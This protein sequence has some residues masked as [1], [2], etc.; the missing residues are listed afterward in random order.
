M[1]PAGIY[2]IQHDVRDKPN[3]RGRFRTDSAGNFYFR[4]VVPSPYPI[5]ERV[6]LHSRVFPSTPHVYIVLAIRT[7]VLTS[8]NDDGD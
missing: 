8:A 3:G 4:G 2:D 7:R 5:P 6:R 1:F